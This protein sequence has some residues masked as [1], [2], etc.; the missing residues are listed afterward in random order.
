MMQENKMA[1]YKTRK[2]NHTAH[3]IFLRAVVVVKVIA[4]V[5]ANSFS[6]G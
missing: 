3:E 4:V 1:K 5:A 2:S 6:M